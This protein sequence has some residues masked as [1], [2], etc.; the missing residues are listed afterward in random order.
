MPVAVRSVLYCNLQV[1]YSSSSTRTGLGR[2]P[3]VIPNSVLA[4]NWRSGLE[5]EAEVFFFFM[6]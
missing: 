3:V 2:W 4:A 5:L 1:R 6:V